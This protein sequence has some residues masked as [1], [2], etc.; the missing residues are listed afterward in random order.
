[1]NTEQHYA[2][3]A[4]MLPMLLLAIWLITQALA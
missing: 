4:S 1:M 3:P 2:H